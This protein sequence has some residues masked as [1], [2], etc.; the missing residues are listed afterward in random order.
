MFK[1]TFKKFKKVNPLSD[2]QEVIDLDNYDANNSTNGLCNVSRQYI[3]L[4]Y[5]FTCMHMHSMYV[6]IKQKKNV[7]LFQSTNLSFINLCFMSSATTL[8]AL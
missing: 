8:P 5:M 4:I 1:Q 3:K 7:N 2:L 6:H